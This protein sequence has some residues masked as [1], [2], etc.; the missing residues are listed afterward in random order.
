MWTL[1]QVKLLGGAKKSLSADMIS[2]D[3]NDLTISELVDY[4]QKMKPADTPDLDENNLI[5]AV[6]GIDSSALEGKF[7]KLKND[8]IVTIIPIIHGGHL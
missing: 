7:T 4:L 5:I 8:D 2:I 6:N 1:I 3:I